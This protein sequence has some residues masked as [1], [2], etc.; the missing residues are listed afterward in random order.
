MEFGEIAWQHGA[1]LAP[2]TT[3]SRHRFLPKEIN[4]ALRGVAISVGIGH[5]LQCEPAE[6]IGQRR[7]CLVDALRMRDELPQID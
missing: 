1:I 7:A 3:R 4:L 2:G 5:R 6:V